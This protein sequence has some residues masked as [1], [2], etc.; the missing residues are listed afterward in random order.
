[1]FTQE[2]A[3][4]IC[5]RLEAGQSLRAA[6]AASDINHATV[7]LWTKTFPT[8][9]NQYTRAREVGYQ[10]LADQIIEISDSQTGDVA[11]DRLSVDSRKWMLSKMLPK[12]YGDK[13][14]TTIQAGETITGIA[15]KI[16]K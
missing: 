13:V 3:D 4:Q 8:F 9:A 11:R 16:L 6:A 14:E 15:R 10:L 7:L 2:V 1:M 5:Q 12:V